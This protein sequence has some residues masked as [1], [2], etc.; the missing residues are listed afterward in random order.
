MFLIIYLKKALLLL[1]EKLGILEIIELEFD[2]AV[3][4]DLFTIKNYEK[5]D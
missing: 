5:F 3:H 4:F 2:D 1:I